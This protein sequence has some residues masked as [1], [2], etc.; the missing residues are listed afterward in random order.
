MA[1]G[2]PFFVVVVPGFGGSV[3]A[4][5][6]DGVVWDSALGSVV[7]RLVD[8]DILGLSSGVP[9]GVVPAGL[10][11]STHV[12]PWMTVVHGYDA[13][14]GGAATLWGS[15]AAIDR[16]DPAR[17]DDR[18][19]VVGFAYD[20]RRGVE[21]AAMRLA[22]DIEARVAARRA[23][24]LA[25]RVVTVAH[26][27][28]GLVAR[29]WIAR[30]G[31]HEHCERLF[32]LGTP[33]LGSLKAL[34]VL[35]NGIGT[36][37]L[38]RRGAAAV[39][40]S[41]PGT[42][43]LVPRWRCLPTAAGPVSPAPRGRA[44]RSDDKSDT[45]PGRWPREATASWLDARQ[46]SQAAVRLGEVDDAWAELE[47]HGGVPP[48]R[49]MVG[50]AHGT[51]QHVVSIDPLV[52][53]DA[54]PPW[55]DPSGLAGDGTVAWSSAVPPGCAFSDPCVWPASGRHGALPA[56]PEVLAALHGLVAPHPSGDRG[57]EQ[58]VGIRTDMPEVLEPGQ[59]FRLQASVVGHDGSLVDLGG[60][61][62]V[63]TVRALTDEVPGIP[64]RLECTT[65]GGG[66]WEAKAV[67]DPG[68]HEVTAAVS[69]A[70]HRSPP[71]VVQR[72]AV[73]AENAFP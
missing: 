49:A 34:D 69:G 54:R 53:S 38:R 73:A 55:L 58:W 48:W 4:S 57:F 26:S 39:L 24:G 3:L 60:A 51:P 14:L 2:P 12:T 18:A 63:V 66:S 36:G 43:D 67:L 6:Q 28:G 62:V 21:Q 25:T 59:P 52:L 61:V 50:I 13:L 33:F 47:S 23:A 30:F 45:S 41:W 11:T 44:T 15:G 9:D 10:I 7:R 27:M 1:T 5:E 40:A 70:A 65:D 68:F 71:A 8:P 20:F 42:F 17:R 31:G 16:G 56:A 37:R 72:V 64:V 32:T 35:A 22:V 29:A 46:V 19:D